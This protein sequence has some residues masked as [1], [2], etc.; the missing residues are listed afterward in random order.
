MQ[1]LREVDSEHLRPG[2]VVA[3]DIDH[4]HPRIAMVQGVSASG[5]KDSEGRIRSIFPLLRAIENP[6][7]Y[8]PGEFLRDKTWKLAGALSTR[9]AVNAIREELTAG[10]LSIPERGITSGCDPEIF[11]TEKSGTLLPAQRFLPA[12]AEVKNQYG[13]YQFWDGYQAEFCPT[14][15][16]CLQQLHDE[17]YAGLMGVWRKAQ[18]YHP[19]AR[20]TLQNTMEIPEALAKT[21]PEEEIRFRCSPS[22]NVYDDPGEPLPDAREYRWRFAGGHLH[23]GFGS[24]KLTVPLIEELVRGLDGILAVAGVSLAEGIDTP[25]RRKMYGRAGEFRLPVHGLEYRVLSNFWLSSPVISNLV[26]ELFRQAI[27]FAASGM[28]RH[29]WEANQE[30]IREVINGCDVKRAREIL[31][32]NKHILA[33]L[34]KQTFKNGRD[35][36]LGRGP[37]GFGPAKQVIYTDAY[38]EKAV[39]TVLHGVNVVVKDPTNVQGNW[40]IGENKWENLGGHVD[41]CWASLGCLQSKPAQSVVAPA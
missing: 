6:G 5:D 30:E 26:F 20:L 16:N 29:C 15:K 1:K 17:I 13:G 38:W 21:A 2:D 41:T 14:A 10:T 37:D 34:F 33:Y 35:V 11:V 36:Y 39:E 22:M 7:V 18:K 12:E 28:Y 3:Q 19:G 40:L 23:A 4:K 25:E 24:K 9:K 8:A 31:D 32:A 27:R